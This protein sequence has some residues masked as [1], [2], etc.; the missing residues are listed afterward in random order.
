M[1]N[2]LVRSIS[3]AIYVAMMAG[4]TIAGGGW[5]AAMLALLAAIG[6]YEFIAMTSEAKFPR[7]A[8]MFDVASGILL[9]L[10]SY[11]IFNGESPTASVLAK[12]YLV[13]IIARMIAQLYASHGNPV[14]SL[15]RSL[16]AQVYIALPLA[17]ICFA[18]FTVATPHLILALL[19]FIWVNDT[20]A[21]CIGSSMGKHKLFERISPKKT[22]EGFWGGMLFCVIAAFIMRGAFQQYFGCMTYGDMCRL[23]ILV[24]IFATFG[25]LLESMIKRTVNVKD[26]GRIIPGHGGILDRIDSLLLVVPVATLYFVMTL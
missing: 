5:L 26:S 18:Y 2:V 15:A 24:S 6:I 12:L 25:D 7:V 16:M 23:G 22:W 1:K 3:G 10:S 11:F 9:V 19:I 17:M 4:A 13:F 20:G 14:N 8:T 21:F